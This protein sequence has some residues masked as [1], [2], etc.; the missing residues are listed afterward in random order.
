MELTIE[1]IIKIIL[2]LLVVAVI[3]FAVYYFFSHSFMDVFK[4]F[5][6]NSTAK[7]FVSLFY[8]I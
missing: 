8:L 1:N 5:G 7:F 4:N 3:A 2:G 6:S